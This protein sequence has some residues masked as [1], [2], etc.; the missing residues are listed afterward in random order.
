MER[1]NSWGVFLSW[2]LSI[3]LQYFYNTQVEFLKMFVFFVPVS[4]CNPIELNTLEGSVPERQWAQT[5]AASPFKVPS[6]LSNLCV[7]KRNLPQ[8]MEKRHESRLND[9]RIV[10][11]PFVEHY[12]ST[13]K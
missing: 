7:H 4:N 3:S 8:N 6:L 12:N 11:L 9:S 10:S 1:V 5:W 2:T 13:L